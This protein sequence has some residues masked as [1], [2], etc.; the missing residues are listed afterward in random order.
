MHD[1]D[2]GTRRKTKQ[3]QKQ[4]RSNTL[5]MI[6]A[7]ATSQITPGLVSGGRMKVYTPSLNAQFDSF[8]GMWSDN[9]DEGADVGVAA[10]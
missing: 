10:L 7:V 8:A 9:G 3:Q 4:K 2:K 6:C 5:K 1:G